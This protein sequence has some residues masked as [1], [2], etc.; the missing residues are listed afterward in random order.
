MIVTVSGKT[1]TAAVADSQVPSE[2]RWPI[3]S[4]RRVGRGRRYVF[5]CTPRQ[6]MQIATHLEDIADSLGG[7]SDFEARADAAACRRDAQR[8]M[9]SFE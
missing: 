5:D 3:P 7:S 2:E 4:M 1:H 6:A 8:I 9:E